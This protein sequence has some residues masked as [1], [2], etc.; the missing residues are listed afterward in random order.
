MEG[1]TG[2]DDEG[3]MSAWYILSAA[4]LHP[5]C[6]G[7]NRFELTSPLF[8]K[9]VFQLD[10][11]YFSG[12]KFT[13]ICHGSRE[14]GNIYIRKARLNGKPLQAC[15]IDFSSISAG[16][17]LELWLGSEPNLKWGTE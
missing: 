11:R 4:G 10:G 17:T 1:L 9:V 16:G 13:V 8:S 6:P 12:K 3:Q 14:S 2:N 5:C 15:W 7:D